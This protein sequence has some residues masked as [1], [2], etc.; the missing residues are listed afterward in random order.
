LVDLRLKNFC[1]ENPRE[2]K[3]PKNAGTP[4]KRSGEQKRVK[5]DEGA[6]DMTFVGGGI[7]L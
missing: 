4:E 3:P 2:G 1:H 6:K 7:H 5:G